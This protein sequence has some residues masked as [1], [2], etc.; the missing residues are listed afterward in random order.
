[1]ASRSFG[2]DATSFGALAKDL[3]DMKALD[4]ELSRRAEA[5]VNG[6]ASATLGADRKHTGKGRGWGIPL[7]VQTKR[8]K[9]GNGILVIPTRY[10]AGPWTEVE[11]GRNQGN[12]GGFAG[13]GVN[14]KTGETARTKA[15][16]VRKVRATRARR[17]NG[18]TPARGA[19]SA[20]VVA[21]ERDLAPVVE[22]AVIALNKKHL[23]G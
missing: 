18:T 13:P 3:S 11:Q 15:G 21:M 16:K 6:V 4:A 2:G 1:M 10:S 8:L 14:R 22:R 12:A 7:D 23:G 20:A 9:E 5:V 17:W 19:A